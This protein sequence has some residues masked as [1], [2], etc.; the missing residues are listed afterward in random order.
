MRENVCLSRFFLFP[1]IKKKEIGVT[2]NK[3]DRGGVKESNANEAATW[4]SE[5]KKNCMKEEE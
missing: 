2:K 3:G 5:E 4:M 1:E